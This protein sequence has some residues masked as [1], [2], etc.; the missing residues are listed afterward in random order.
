MLIFFSGRTI[1]LNRL[2]VVA[3]S[4]KVRYQRWDIKIRLLI[5]SQIRLFDGNPTLLKY[6]SRLGEPNVIYDYAK[7]DYY[8]G[9]QHLQ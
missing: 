2:Y 8:D 9:Q 4:T 1:P 6:L 5:A 3:P 7:T